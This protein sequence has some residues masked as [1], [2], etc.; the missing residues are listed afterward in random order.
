MQE[1]AQRYTN[2]RKSKIHTIYKNTHNATQLYK[3]ISQC[4]YT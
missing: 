2:T 1:Y 4:Q 3:K